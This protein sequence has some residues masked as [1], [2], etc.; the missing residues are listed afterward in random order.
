LNDLNYLNKVGHTERDGKIERYAHT[1]AVCDHE[2]MRDPVRP[3]ERVERALRARIAAGEWAR[4]EQL[5]TVAELAA[6]YRVSRG[7]VAAVIK[8]LADD[9]LVR[10]VRAWGTFRT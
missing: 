4:D 10:T 9:G 7:T 6:E 2:W 3:A 8:R 5:P 1:K